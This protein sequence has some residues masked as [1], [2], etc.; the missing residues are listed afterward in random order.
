MHRYVLVLQSFLFQSYSPTTAEKALSLHCWFL[1]AMVPYWLV[2]HLL[3]K[4]IVLRVTT[5]RQILV[6]NLCLAFLPWLAFI[7]PIAIT[8]DYGPYGEWYSSHRTGSTA[9]AVDLWSVV[10]K[11]N[12]VSYIHVFVFGMCLARFVS[13][14]V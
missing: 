1:S 2:F 4:H 14:S 11:F 13:Q 12:P 9:T 8:D 10:V 7:F 5:M 6:L 3:I